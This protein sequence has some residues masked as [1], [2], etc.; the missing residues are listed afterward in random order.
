MKRLVIDRFEGKYAICEDEKG[1]MFGIEISEMPKEAKE[2]DVIDISDD[3][4]ITV[5]KDE[6]LKR[7]K[8]IQSKTSKL[9][10]K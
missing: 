8:R 9:F 4:I 5:N 2:S 6:T 1:G 7:S 10:N 3:G